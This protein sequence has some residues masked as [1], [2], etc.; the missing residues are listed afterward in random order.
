MNAEEQTGKEK[1]ANLMITIFPCI[2]N[3]NFAFFMQGHFHRNNYLQ[4][5]CKTIANSGTIS[6][7][8]IPQFY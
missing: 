8:L 7:S 4:C 2:A 3:L 1:N 5:I 6:H